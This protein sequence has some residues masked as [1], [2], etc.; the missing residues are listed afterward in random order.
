M[1]MMIRSILMFSTN[2]LIYRTHTSYN[3]ISSV[4]L[5]HFQLA[6]FF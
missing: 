4:D 2:I 3:S 1:K 6:P 5:K